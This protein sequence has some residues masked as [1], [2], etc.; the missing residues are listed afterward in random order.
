MQRV[1]PG[2]RTTV[3]LYKDQ[4]PREKRKIEGSFKSATAESITLLLPSG[5]RRTLRKQAVRKVL[6]Y[7]PPLERHQGWI[8]TGVFAA[9]MAAL[10][11]DDVEI[12]AWGVPL[13]GV[14]S[15]IAFLVAPK[16][17]GIYDVSAKHRDDPIQTPAKQSSSTTVPWLKESEGS[18]TD[19][20]AKDNF[21]LEQSSPDRLRQQARQALLRKGLPLRLPDL[22]VRGLAAE[23]TGMQTTFDGSFPERMR[24]PGGLASIEILILDAVYPVRGCTWDWNCMGASII[25]P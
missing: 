25:F 21:L 14:P 7:R 12:D 16:M 13:L 1:T 4:A 8:V 3:V 17:G 24:F 23:R 15:A 5:Q 6:V 9:L 18:P 19:S 11:A 2:T 22:T 20:G 10:L